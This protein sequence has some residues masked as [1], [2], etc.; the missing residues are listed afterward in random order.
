[1]GV[2]ASGSVATTRRGFLAGQV[3][4]QD[5]SVS[6]GGGY[7]SSALTP[8]F[9]VYVLGRLGHGP[10]GA[11]TYSIAHFNSLGATD[12]ERLVAFVDQ[13]LA[14]S[15]D[16]AGNVTDPDVDARLAHPSYYT[17]GKSFAQLWT[18]HEVNGNP[19][20]GQPNVRD[21]PAREGERAVFV[22]AMYSRWQLVERMAE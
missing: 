2:P 20:G 5:K 11:S 8:P 6:G 10:R 14:P 18:D 12:D 4:A 21:H 22:R 19:G 13:Q 9:A 3:A 15:V 7:S 17:L 1:M 16:G